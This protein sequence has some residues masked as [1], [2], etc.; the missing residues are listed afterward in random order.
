ML[1]RSAVN[2]PALLQA[3]TMI[4]REKALAHRIQLDTRVDPGLGSMLADE[5]KLKQ[6]VYNLLS[7]AIKF[8][9]EGGT[10]T[11]SAHRCARAEV[12]LDEAMPARLL[13][14]PPGADG[15]FLAV[16]VEDSGMG[17]A[18]EDLHKLYEPFSRSEERRVGKECRL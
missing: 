18:E 2:I 8:T 17:I 10:V 13:P 9:V 15:E 1:F 5:R 4:V 3:S 12:A 6:I 14:L 16:S 11:L 7:N